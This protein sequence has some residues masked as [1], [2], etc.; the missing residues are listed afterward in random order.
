MVSNV[1]TEELLASVSKDE[2]AIV[3]CDTTK[4]MMVWELYRYW[5]PAGYDRAVHL[6]ERKFYDESHFFR[7][8]PNFLVQ[9][10][11]SYTTDESL[12]QLALQRIP[13]DPQ[14]NPPIPFT[15]G[16][17]SYAGT[18]NILR[19]HCTFDAIKVF[20]NAN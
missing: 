11:I 5:S 14:H 17:I 10:G 9:F 16:T 1:Y 2:I 6:L 4:G 15:L 20:Y 8:V 19:H 3:S 18:L 7:T 12:Q 13:D